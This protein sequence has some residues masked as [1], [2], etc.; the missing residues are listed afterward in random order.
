MGQ[1]KK[2]AEVPEL[3]AGLQMLKTTHSRSN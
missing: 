1:E 2:C 3:S